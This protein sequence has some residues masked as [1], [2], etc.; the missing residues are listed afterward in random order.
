MVKIS[1]SMFQKYKN[2]L[3]IYVNTFFMKL[4]LKLL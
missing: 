2:D 3:H 4:S 1:V